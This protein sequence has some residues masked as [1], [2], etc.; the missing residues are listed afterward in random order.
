MTGCLFVS[1]WARFN[2][3]KPRQVALQLAAGLCPVRL[4]RPETGKSCTPFPLSPPRFPEDRFQRAPGIATPRESTFR[5]TV[6][7]IH[8]GYLLMGKLTC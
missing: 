6:Q 2:A 3:K 1:D 7:G 4:G 8:P 5:K